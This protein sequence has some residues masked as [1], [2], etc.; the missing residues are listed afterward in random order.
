MKNAHTAL[1]AKE[2]EIA[3]SISARAVKNLRA[4]VIAALKK[5]GVKSLHIEWSDGRRS[6]VEVS[7]MGRLLYN[8]RKFESLRGFDVEEH[9]NKTEP[10]QKARFIGAVMGNAENCSNHY[11]LI[12][13]VE[14]RA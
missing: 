9:T 11:Y 2:N 6:P 7:P 3:R 4:R 5:H 13:K 10:R 14:G 1:L 8:L 12:A